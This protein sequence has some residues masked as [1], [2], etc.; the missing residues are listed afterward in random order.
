MA[1]KNII[2]FHKKPD[3]NNSVICSARESVIGLIVDIVPTYL[4]VHPYMAVNLAVSAGPINALGICEGSSP[5]DIHF[6]TIQ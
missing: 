2:S 6:E 5:I 3:L 1:P 4:T